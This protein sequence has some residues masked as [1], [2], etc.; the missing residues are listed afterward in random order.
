MS[1]RNLSLAA[2]AADP[3]Q[4]Q[5]AVSLEWQGQTSDTWSL[6]RNQSPLVK[7]QA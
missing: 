4:K 3:F 6:L 7:R 1:H 5:N 2:L